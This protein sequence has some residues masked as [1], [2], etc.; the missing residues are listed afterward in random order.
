MFPY[1]CTPLVILGFVHFY[2]LFNSIASNLQEPTRLLR[3]TFSAL[4][5]VLPMSSVPS[6]S[7][8]LLSAENSFSF[9]FVFLAKASHAEAHWK[10][11]ASLSKGLLCQE[12][13]YLI[14]WLQLD[15][16]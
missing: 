11:I 2:K 9:L 14:S 16:S 6:L 4:K 7:V 8:T 13:L 5:L 12:L 10:K 1:V 15:D 3:V